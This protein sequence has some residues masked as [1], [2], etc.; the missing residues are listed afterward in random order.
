MNNPYAAV[1][2]ASK[3][4]ILLLT[5]AFVIGFWWSVFRFAPL[6]P[7]LGRAV[8][9]T[10]LESQSESSYARRRIARGGAERDL[11]EVASYRRTGVRSRSG[12]RV[13]VREG[14][15][16]EASGLSIRAIRVRV[17]RERSVA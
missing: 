2:V 14:G 4:S 8:R 5:I 3:V 10:V 16:G 15:R 17:A 13:R 12:T 9:T 7:D 1:R 6:L 11:G